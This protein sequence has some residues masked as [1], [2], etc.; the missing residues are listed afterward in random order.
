M[1]CRYLS[2]LKKDVMAR[3]KAEK[4]RRIDRLRTLFATIERAKQLQLNR[5]RW[6]VAQGTC[7]LPC[8]VLLCLAAT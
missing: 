5:W 3:E 2:R 7:R 4:Q 8:L 1:A 6:V